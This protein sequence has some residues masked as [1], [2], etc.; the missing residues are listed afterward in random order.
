MQPASGAAAQRRAQHPPAMPSG[1]IPT[2]PAPTIP[3]PAIGAPPTSGKAI[4]ELIHSGAGP[5]GLFAAAQNMH[6]HAEQL[7]A[8]AANCAA[9]PAP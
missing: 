2:L 5:E 8:P 3:A 6:R 9:A 4:A 7:R 1:T